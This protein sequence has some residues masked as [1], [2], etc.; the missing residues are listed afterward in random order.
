MGKRRSICIKGMHFTNAG[1]LSYHLLQCLEIAPLL[2]LI[3]SVVRIAK[4]S[5]LDRKFML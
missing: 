4:L 1:V 5:K 3:L 2:L